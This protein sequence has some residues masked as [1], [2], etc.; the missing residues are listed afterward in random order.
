MHFQL[1]IDLGSDAMQTASDIGRALIDVGE[2]LHGFG[3]CE[4]GPIATAIGMAGS[5][6]DDNGNRVGAWNVCAD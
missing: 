5:I 6:K 2:H 3:E 4:V 1:R